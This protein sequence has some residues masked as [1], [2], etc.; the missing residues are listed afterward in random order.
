MLKISIHLLHIFRF[1]INLAKN[2]DIAFHFNPRFDELGIKVI[3]RNS[4]I[5]S[6]WGA[7]EKAAPSFPF[8]PGQP[9]EVSINFEYAGLFWFSP[10]HIGAFLAAYC[11][12]GVVLL[13]VHNKMG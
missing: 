3:V 12:F 6:M 8:A 7:E 5:N 10:V 2:K 13:F 9:F 4:M 1:S 11:F